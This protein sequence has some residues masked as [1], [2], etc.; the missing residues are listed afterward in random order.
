MKVL[1]AN[2]GEIAIRIIRTLRE[3]GI[4]SV[5]VYS[6]A[7]QGALHQRFADERVPIGESY[8]DIATLIS[9]A[10]EVGADAVHPGYGFLSERA[11][12]AQACL[13][14]GI[15]FIGPSPEA[16][17]ALGGKIESKQIAVTAGVPITP[18]FFEPGASDAQ[19]E[20]AAIEIGF[21]VMLKASAGGG[22]RG[23]RMVGER[24][25]LLSALALAREEAINA[26]GDG[27]MMVEKLVQQPRH[28]EVQFVADNFGN[29]A[30]L[31]ERE[32]SI[33]RR[34]QKL[35]EECPSPLVQEHPELWNGMRDAAVRLV[36]QARYTGAGTAEF[37][38]DPV[39][40]D[41]YFLE[42]NARLQVEHTV[43]EGVTGL[44]LVRL[45]IEVA[46]GG[47][48]A[49]LIPEYL[50][51]DRARIQGH[52]LEARIVAE[53]PAQGFMPSIG[54]ILAWAEPRGVRVD[55]GYAAGIEVSRHYDSLLAKLVVSAPDR[56]QCL[57]RTC[58]ALEDFHVLGVHTNIAY[59]LDVI[60]HPSFAGG[61]FDTGFLGRQF[62]GWD[63]TAPLPLELSTLVK[64][65]SV[66]A[67]PIEAGEATFSSWDDRGSW[68]NA[69][70]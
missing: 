14:A 48:L 66:S 6:D 40:H 68:R 52:C 53:N 49:D 9:A 55:T 51:G 47:N 42:V 46:Q 54:K 36:K 16:M 13:D 34:H 70:T 2:R 8:L 39:T 63:G 1:I 56:S 33:Q 29:V 17:R 43:T 35:I 24:S 3:L 7:D 11:E 21:P 58:Q 12:F 57:M 4:A 50:S 20:Q 65:A 62:E 18:G 22:G 41:F 10:K 15:T 38:V 69:R 28:I 64:R 30:P 37:I 45:Q 32:C 61:E 26:F 31:F 19:L 25:E 27:A 67:N 60:R 5:A 23:M 59:L 44:D